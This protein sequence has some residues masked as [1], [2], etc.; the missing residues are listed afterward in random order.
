[1]FVY[2]FLKYWRGFS[3]QSK[4]RALLVSFRT[5]AIEKN[6]IMRHQIKD[7]IAELVRKYAETH[8]LIVMTKQLRLE[9]NLESGGSH[10][11]GKDS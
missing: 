3:L 1:M 7:R 10:G 8:D 11:T 6:S 5:T 9:S 2:F 4:I